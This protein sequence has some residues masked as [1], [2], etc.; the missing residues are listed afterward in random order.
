MYNYCLSSSEWGCYKSCRHNYYSLHA[1][2]FACR[3]PVQRRWVWRAWRRRRCLRSTWC[4]AW[5]R[6]SGS[7]R[8]LAEVSAMTSE[9]PQSLYPDSTPTNSNVT[10]VRRLLTLRSY[11]A[12][13]HDTDTDIDTRNSSR[14]SWCRC[15]GM[16]ANKLIRHVSSGSGDSETGCKLRYFNLINCFYTKLQPTGSATVR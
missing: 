12:A 6:R 10:A 11:K 16:Q 9:M 4:T 15:R 14:E 1:G 7:W 13:F 8:E 5:C 3:L 2:V